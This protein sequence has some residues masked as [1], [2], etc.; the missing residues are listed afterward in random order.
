M[1]IWR[2]LF[3]L[4][5]ASKDGG[6]VSVR[7]IHRAGGFH[8]DLDQ[9]GRSMDASAEHVRRHGLPTGL[10]AEY[11]SWEPNQRGN[12]LADKECRRVH[13]LHLDDYQPR[14][15]E[16][17]VQRVTFER[18]YPERPEWTAED[19]HFRFR[20]S[21]AWVDWRNRSPFVD[22]RDWVLP[23]MRDALADLIEHLH[24]VHNKLA[25]QDL[26]AVEVSVEHEPTPSKEDGSGQGWNFAVHAVAV[27]QAVLDEEQRAFASFKAKQT[28]PDGA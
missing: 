15:H 23:P 21:T 2:R 10:I 20:P 6:V 16:H 4:D 8:I 5:P 1:S 24:M 14:S 28:A 27:P 22:P 3:G 11:A 19:M 18:S 26:V 17:G 13:G 12:P 25:E 9:L 7:R